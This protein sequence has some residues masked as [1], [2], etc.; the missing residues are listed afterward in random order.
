LV[1]VVLG[2]LFGWVCCALGR[3][4]W[5]VGVGWFGFVFVDLLVQIFMIFTKIQQIN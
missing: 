2:L 1:L 4:R 3:W 5:R